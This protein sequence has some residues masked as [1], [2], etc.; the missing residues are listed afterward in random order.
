M[1]GG[2][3]HRGKAIA[4]ALELEAKRQQSLVATVDRLV[5]K[6][7]VPRS[8]ICG[9]RT[10]DYVHRARPFRNLSSAIIVT[11][12]PFRDRISRRRPSP[13][14]PDAGAAILFLSCGYSPSTQNTSHAGTDRVLKKYVY[15]R[16]EYRKFRDI[17]R[18]DVTIL[19]DMIEDNHGARQA[20]VALAII[21]KVMNWYASR[22]DDYSAVIV[23]GMHRANDGDRKRSRQRA[24][25]RG[26]L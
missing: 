4:T 13:P 9:G 12:C 18:G 20:D 19:L 23:R 26:R 2:G 16:W 17:K 21:R 15:P 5:V 11:F 25:Q 1:M 14:G 3:R 24:H 6:S 7:H 10:A 22:N 8:G